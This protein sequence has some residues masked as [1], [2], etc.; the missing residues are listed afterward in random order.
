[1][2]I[3][4]LPFL[5]LTGCLPHSSLHA[6][7][8][9]DEEKSA[10]IALVH[11]HRTL[12]AL[13][14]LEALSTHDATIASRCHELAHEVGHTA[15]EML[16]FSG[17]IVLNNDVCGSGYMHGVIEEH[18]E[19]TTDIVHALRTT[20]SITDGRCLHGLGHGLM[21]FSKNDVPWSVR[22]CRLLPN[23]FSQVKCAEGIFMENFEA[24]EESH[25]S[26]YLY[27]DDPAKIC[28]M[29]QPDFRLTCYFYYPRYYLR[30]HHR[31]FDGLR[32]S[33]LSLSNAEDKKICITGVGS[34]AM[35]T[36]IADP[37]RALRECDAFI[38]QNHQSCIEGLVSYSMV[39]FASSKKGEEFC[40]MLSS[41]DATV[42]Q[43]SVLDAQ[44][45]FPF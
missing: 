33:C 21:F 7:R 29:Q 11:A 36:F 20:C 24:D 19:H 38:D 25:P 22:H 15:F 41:A 30:I 42:C 10:L 1:M 45:I 31:D 4:F 5:L 27:P 17:A 13:H 6:P 26:Q 12:D 43:Q 44:G 37:L 34:A 14:Q 40:E 8:S 16:G 28:R 2:R 35:K 9:F 18:F 3:L 23:S 39:H 32:Q